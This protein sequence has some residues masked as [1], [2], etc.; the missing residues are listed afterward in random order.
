MYYTQVHALVMTFQFGICNPANLK[1]DLMAS[2]LIHE[3]NTYEVREQ[4]R[5]QR[6][7]K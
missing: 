7:K 4:K 1:K 3:E 2:E 5:L 6:K